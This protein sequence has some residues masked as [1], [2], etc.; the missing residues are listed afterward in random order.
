MYIVRAISMHSKINSDNFSCIEIKYSYL[1]L[2]VDLRALNLQKVKTIN[3]N[4]QFTPN[5]L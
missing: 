4:C 3:F 5:E 2:H 1:F